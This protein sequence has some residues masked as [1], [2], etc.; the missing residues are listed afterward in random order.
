MSTILTK[1]ELLDYSH[2]LR[3]ELLC[4]IEPGDKT[5]LGRLE[6][7]PL[8]VSKANSVTYD[9][10]KIFLFLWLA[11]KLNLELILQNLP[12][13]ILFHI[14][15]IDFLFRKVRKCLVQN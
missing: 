13:S 5:L 1:N 6:V 7:V 14:L 4:V 8:I 3:K 12:P 15:H 9:V 11:E 10:N 2:K